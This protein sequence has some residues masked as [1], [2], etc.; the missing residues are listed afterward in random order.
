MIS[1][2]GFPLIPRGNN[3]LRRAAKSG[4]DGGF[5][6]APMGESFANGRPSLVTVT[7][8]P[9]AI[10]IETRAKLLRKSRT[11]AVGI[12]IQTSITMYL[13]STGNHQIANGEFHL[14]IELRR[15]DFSRR[16]G[17]TH[18]MVGTNRRR[19]EYPG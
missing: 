11:V 19:E 10:Q 2:N 3:R 7:D 18:S 6:G 12:V 16:V 15:V 17:G 9:F 8:S 13:V 1:L 5:R 4:H 14:Q